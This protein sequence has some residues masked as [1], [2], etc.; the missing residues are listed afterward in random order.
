[1][2]NGP[3]D[4]VK[5]YPLEVAI[6]ENE[7]KDGRPY[8]NATINRTY[9]TGEGKQKEYKQTSQLRKQDLP[10]AA[11]LLEQAWGIINE[12]EDAARARSRPSSNEQPPY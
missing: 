6:W 1:M 7:G 12:L 4:K 11:L 2:A 8:F 5:S 3:I 9:T 10:A